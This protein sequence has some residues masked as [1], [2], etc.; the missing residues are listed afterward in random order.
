ML[1]RLLRKVTMKKSEIYIRDPFV[2]PYKGKYYMYGTR[3]TESWADRATGLD[4]Y[5]SENLESWTGPT[6]VFHRPDDFWATRDFWAPEVHEYNGAFYMFVSLKSDTARRGTFILKADAPDG[7]FKPYSE[8]ITPEGWEALDGT[9]YIDKK[10]NPYMVFS[11][12]WVQINDGQICAVE[13][14]SDLSKAEGKPLTLITASDAPWT[15]TN[16][17]KTYVTDGPFLIRLSSGR[18]AMLWSSFGAEGY[19]IGIAYSSN[20]ELNGKWIHE[21]E[22]LFKSDGGHAMVFETFQGKRLLAFHYPNETT[23]ERPCFYELIENG[24]TLTAYRLDD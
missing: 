17:G 19:A 12:E 4:V 7:L 24:G 13:L 2:L 5:V 10:G 11:H 18:L 20:G 16:D 1:N 6:E 8:R 23:K 22:P 15:V 9:L 21:K 14:A 3:G